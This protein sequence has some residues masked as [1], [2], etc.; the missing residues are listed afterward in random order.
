MKRLLP[1]LALL[2][3]LALPVHAADWDLQ[4][5]FR[6]DVEHTDNVRLD[7][8]RFADEDE[9]SD[10][11]YRGSLRLGLIRTSER[12]ELR[13]HY[14]PARE[15]FAEFSDF[16]NTTHSA[17]LTFDF[18]TTPRASWGITAAWDKRERTRVSLEEGAELFD[19]VTFGTVETETLRA[20]IQGLLTASERHRWVVAADASDTSYDSQDVEDFTI[21]DASSVGAELAWETDLAE[22]TVFGFSTRAS[23]VDEGARGTW[24]VY[25]LLS[26][27]RLGSP[28]RLEMTLVAGAAKP[29]LDDPGELVE[30]DVR[31]DTEFVARLGL[32][33]DLGA[34]SNL[35]LGVTSDLAGSRG[36]GGLARSDSVY[37]RWLSRV[38]PRARISLGGNWT[39]RDPLEDRAISEEDPLAGEDRGLE[40]LGFRAE[41]AYAFASRWDLVIG[42]ETID[43]TSESETVLE[44][45]RRIY[46]AGIRWSP[47]AEGR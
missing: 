42:A 43:Q 19:L 36:V 6:V 26:A 32:S 12:S 20:R 1:L 7:D 10:I 18:S 33:R 30:E 4:P 29:S 28:E 47:L 21:E 45:D 17:G 8:P 14:T 5:V 15:A 16:D 44:V 37:L 22:R 9:E 25:E 23:Q 13:F 3:A 24:N 27:L 35:N 34:R 38:S 39:S 40:T 2:A 11:I 41:F 31:E 46:R